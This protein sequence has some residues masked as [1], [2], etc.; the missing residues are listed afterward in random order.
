[1]ASLYAD[2]GSGSPGYAPGEFFTAE[3]S[4]AR[5]EFAPEVVVTGMKTLVRA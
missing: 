1:M 2:V 5:F 4:V 3:A